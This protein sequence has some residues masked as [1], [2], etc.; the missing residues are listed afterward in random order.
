MHLPESLLFVYQV[1]G[2]L[3]TVGL[4]PGCVQIEIEG[5][6]GAA[7]GS[8]IE[9]LLVPSVTRPSAGE[10]PPQNPM[11]WAWSRKPNSFLRVARGASLAGERVEGQE[12][13]KPERGQA[14]AALPTEP[15]GVRAMGLL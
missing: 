4:T 1:G 3:R 7:V 11:P 14:V 9:C 12:R 8:F 2:S 6:G 15:C 13:E 5:S 10:R